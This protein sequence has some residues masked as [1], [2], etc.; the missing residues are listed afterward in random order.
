MDQ[1]L[2]NIN[3]TWKELTDQA[4]QLSRASAQLKELEGQYAERKARVEETGAIYRK[5]QDD[6]D[7]LEQGGLRAFFASLAGDK[8]ERLS[9]ERREALAAKCQYD[10]AMSDLEYL[11]NKIRELRRQQ[12]E[13][14]QVRQKLDT[15]SQIK[16]KLLKELGGETGE[17][18]MELDQQQA[19][20][21]HQLRE[22]R[23]ALSAG[24]RAE[25][26]LSQVLD[27][28][29]SARDWGV[30]DMVGGGMISTMMK[31]ERI[32]DVRDGL[33]Q[34][35]RALSDFRTELA[36]VGNIQVPDVEIGSFATFADY[37]FDNIF[38][39][40]YV[41]S[42]IH[43]AQ[44]GVSEVHM[45]VL[46]ALH[47]LEQAELNLDVELEGLKVRRSALLDGAQS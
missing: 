22:V 31:H 13:L 36:D 14:K 21:E 34:V 11:E 30:W 25:T 2:E 9:K 29:D 24:K 18:L 41:Q 8:E 16:A 45:K 35:Q 47:T 42:N 3:R 15:L 43:D 28:L 40:W 4:S 39:D 10:Q 46:S 27:S 37:F 33:R 26:A 5:E 44:N 12:E 32:G 17:Q 7:K 38:V 6:V 1:R 19:E 20:L 23:E